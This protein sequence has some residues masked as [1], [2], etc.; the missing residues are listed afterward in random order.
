MILQI[1]KFVS[2][3]FQFYGKIWVIL[4]IYGAVNNLG[5]RIKRKGVTLFSTSYATPWEGFFK[6]IQIEDLRPVNR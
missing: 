4:A 1:P 2:N 6:R 5:N 3:L